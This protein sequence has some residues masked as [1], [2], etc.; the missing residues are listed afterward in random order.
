MDSD[1]RL[2]ALLR[3][4]EFVS[5]EAIAGALGISRAAVAKRVDELR[6]RGFDIAAAPRRGYRLDARARRAHA[7]TWSRRG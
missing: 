2:L 7:P 4:D 5:G 6:K 3:A 1:E